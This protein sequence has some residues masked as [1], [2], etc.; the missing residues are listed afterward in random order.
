MSVSLHFEAKIDEFML[1]YVSL[2]YLCIFY[3]AAFLVLLLVLSYINV[4]AKMIKKFR[5]L[6]YYLFIFLA[7]VVSPPDIFSQFFISLIAIVLYEFLVFA[8]MIKF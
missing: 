1:V 3:C 8:S 6:Y 4:N 2:Y 7:T 5:K